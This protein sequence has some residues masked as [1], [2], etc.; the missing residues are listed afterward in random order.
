MCLPLWVKPSALTKAHFHEEASRALVRD[1]AR[2][3]LR[4][5]IC[6]RTPNLTVVQPIPPC[7]GKHYYTSACSECM[8]VITIVL[9]IPI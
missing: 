8:H 3:D 1:I 4:M 5:H 9:V 2:A 6:M 7:Y